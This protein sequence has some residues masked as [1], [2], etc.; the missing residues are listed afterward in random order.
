MTVTYFQVPCCF[1]DSTDDSCE[2]TLIW[3]KYVH[4]AGSST[5][6]QLL[7]ITPV[8]MTDVLAIPGMTMLIILKNQ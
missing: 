4:L 2:F 3:Y 5:L 7:K 8:H 1:T 6:R